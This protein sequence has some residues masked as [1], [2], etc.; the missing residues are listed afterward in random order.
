[1]LADRHSGMVRRTRPQMCNCTSGN[2][3]IPGSRLR[4]ALSDKRYALARGM[5]ATVV[6]ANYF[7]GFGW[8][9]AMTPFSLRESR[10]TRA[11]TKRSR[12]LTMTPRCFLAIGGSGPRRTGGEIFSNVKAGIVYPLGAELKHPWNFPR[13]RWNKRRQRQSVPPAFCLS[14]I[15]SEDRYPLFRIMLWRG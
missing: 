11:S 6:D 12:I 4:R 7:C 5:T 13:S 15:V 10:F 8:R 1:M 3:E 2:L 14:M 9:R